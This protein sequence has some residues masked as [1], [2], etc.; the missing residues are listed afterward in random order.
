MRVAQKATPDIMSVEDIQSALNTLGANPQVDVSGDYDQA[1][2][3]AVANFQG[4]HNCDVDGWVGPQTT[5][6]IKAALALTQT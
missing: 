4:S 6:A 2:K 1:T 3:T 5:A